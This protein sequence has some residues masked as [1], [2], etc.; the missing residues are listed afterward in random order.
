MVFTY[1]YHDNGVI[2]IYIDYYSLF[3]REDKMMRCCA[4]LGR[5]GILFFSGFAASLQSSS[6]PRFTQH[7][8]NW[9][10]R[11]LEGVQT[12]P[13]HPSHKQSFC[14]S[15]SSVSWKARKRWQDVQGPLP[16]VISSKAPVPPAPFPATAS[17]PQ[18]VGSLLCYS[19]WKPK[20]GIFILGIWSE[21]AL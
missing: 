16:I 7:A 18:R 6:K 13:G 2:L 9:K 5:V 21:L 20:I 1:L 11:I 17:V 3:G 15:R 12:L 8:T 14:S 19:C 10:H 4:L